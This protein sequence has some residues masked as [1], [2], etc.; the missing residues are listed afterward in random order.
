MGQLEGGVSALEWSPDGETVCLITGAG[1]MLLMT[2]VRLQARSAPT[3]TQ[4]L[5]CFIKEAW[6]SPAAQPLVA[7]CTQTNATNAK[8]VAWQNA[9]MCMH[10]YAWRMSVSSFN[11]PRTPPD[12][13]SWGTGRSGTFWGRSRCWAMLRQLGGMCV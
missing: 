7:W 10:M 8:S 4:R 13:K 9:A 1:Q 2:K 6:L 11:Q 3:E 12:V 5:L